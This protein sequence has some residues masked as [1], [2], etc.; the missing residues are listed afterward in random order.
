MED[1]API[2]SQTEAQ[3][4]MNAMGISSHQRL[5]QHVLDHIDI[6]EWVQDWDK[7]FDLHVV[8][9]IQFGHAPSILGELAEKT[10]LDPLDP[11]FFLVEGM[12]V[13]CEEEDAELTVVIQTDPHTVF[14]EERP[15]KAY[16]RAQLQV[17]DY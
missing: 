17:L 9:L 15:G 6:P 8:H 14:V 11:L 2:M 7:Q 16:E 13:Y 5:V 1:T 3:G 4:I 12:M 10:I